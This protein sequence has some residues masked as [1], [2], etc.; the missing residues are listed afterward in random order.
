MKLTSPWRCSL[1]QSFDQGQQFVAP[2]IGLCRRV[3]DLAIV[4]ATVGRP[5][6]GRIQDHFARHST[7]NAGRI[8]EILRKIGDD[9]DIAG[10]VGPYRYRPHDLVEVEWIDVLVDDD[11]KLRVTEAVRRGQNAHPD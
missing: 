11:H 8:E 9:H 10:G 7:R 6:R 3:E 4:P 1:L 5:W 2:G